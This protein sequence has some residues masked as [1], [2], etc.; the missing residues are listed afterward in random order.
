MYYLRS[1]LLVAAALGAPAL[2]AQLANSVTMPTP[3]K[4]AYFNDT[5]TETAVPGANKPAFSKLGPEMRGDIMMAR[6]MY[7]EAAEAYGEG[8]SD[9]AILANKTGI[10]YH[11]MMQLDV[12]RKKYE[13]ALKLNPGYSEA[14]N[15]LGTV[16]YAK[17]NYRKAV[18]LY[19]KALKIAPQSAS[20]HSNL[21]T[22]EFARKRYKE[23][24]EAYEIALKLDPEVFEH[25]GANGVL[26][27]ERS[28]QERAKFHYYLAKTYAKAGA[29][30]RALMYIRKAIEEGFKEREKFR[31]DPEF[32]Q[33][34]DLP[35]FKLLLASEPRVL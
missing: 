26:L 8:D 24:A 12:A 21:G 35:E 25:R 3:A 20:I 2:H 16:Y 14:I 34:Q 13:R 5:R 15:N 11:Q 19:R 17:K 28:V 27:Q 31:E 32:A 6:K 10:A 23:A 9:S 1:S 22:A 33:L 30:E 29:S 4:P 18:G 7:R